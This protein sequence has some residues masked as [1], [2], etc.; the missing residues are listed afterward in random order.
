MASEWLLEMVGISKSFPGVRA[1]DDVCLRVRA[2]SVHA[3][4]GENG[5]GKSTLMK[6]LNGMYRPDAGE[7]RLRGE[8]VQINGLK[9]ALESLLV[10]G[11][12]GMGHGGGSVRVGMRL[13]DSLPAGGHVRAGAR[14]DAGDGTRSSSICVVDIN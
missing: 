1:L 3:L 10:F 12:E 2:G 8:P 14:Q 6:V 9:G 13:A 11:E 4:I 7:I 5:A